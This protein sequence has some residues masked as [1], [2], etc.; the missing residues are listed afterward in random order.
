MDDLVTS[1]PSMKICPEVGFSRPATKRKMVVLPQPDGPSN[2]TMVPRLMVK[3]KSSITTD[4]PKAFVTF[5][6]TKKS[7][8]IFFTYNLIHFFR[9][10]TG[11]AGV[12]DNP[13][14]E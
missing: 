5:F 13:V 3:S 4:L 11:N 1:S 9:F 2:V 6:N 14:E 10:G 7:L 12:T 8:L